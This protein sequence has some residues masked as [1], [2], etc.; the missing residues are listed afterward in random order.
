M[1]TRFPGS[2]ED[3]LTF[4]DSIGR[5]C[6][7]N[8]RRCVNKAVERMLVNRFV[9]GVIPADAEPQAQQCC[10][11]HRG[12]FLFTEKWQVVERIQLQTPGRVRD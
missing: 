3:R 1:P 4:L 6:D 10:G 2:V 8:N 12:A 7:A 9:D 5:R 11:R